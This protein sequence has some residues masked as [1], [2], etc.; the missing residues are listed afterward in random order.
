MPHALN[1]DGA[2]ES[3]FLIEVMLIIPPVSLRE[4]LCA[5]RA[6]AFRFGNPITLLRDL[7]VLAVNHSS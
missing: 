2:S 1:I 6:S 5:L 4:V 3:L 7:G